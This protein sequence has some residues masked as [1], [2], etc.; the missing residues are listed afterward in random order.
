MV[1]VVPLT[2]I[3]SN[4]IEHSAALSVFA[5]PS[6]TSTESFS[7]SQHKQHKNIQVRTEESVLYLNNFSHLNEIQAGTNQ[8][9]TILVLPSPQS[10]YLAVPLLNK[11]I[12][13]DSA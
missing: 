9:C 5:K 8:A 6:T 10:H 2:Q 12:F 7:F 13:T 3:L 1:P 11:V 4:S